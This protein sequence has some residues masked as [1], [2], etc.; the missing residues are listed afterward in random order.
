M[1]SPALTNDLFESE[2]EIYRKFLP[3]VSP[4]EGANPKTNTWDVPYTIGELSYLVHSHYRYYGKF[5]SVV[6]GQ[7]LDQ[8]PPPSK[9]HYVL[10]NFCGSGTAAVISISMSVPHGGDFPYST[11]DMCQACFDLYGVGAAVEH[12]REL[13]K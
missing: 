1:S 10:D 13:T 5:P 4:V 7:L 3:I 2:I 6:A 8:F 11:T 12:N 9:E